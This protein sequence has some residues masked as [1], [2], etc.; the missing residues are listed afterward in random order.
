[1]PK[2][3]YQASKS[4]RIKKFGFRRRMKS[5]KGQLVLKKRRIRGRKNIAL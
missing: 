5:K 1:M 4:K 2:R 3:T